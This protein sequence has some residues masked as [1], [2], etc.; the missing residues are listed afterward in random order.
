MAL[1]QNFG[2]RK[3]IKN[4]QN[5]N[6]DPPRDD[7]RLRRDD[8][9]APVR[10]N[11]KQLKQRAGV[12]VEIGVRPISVHHPG[13]QLR[14]GRNAAHGRHIVAP[15]AAGSVIRRT[16]SFLR[17]LHLEKVLKANVEQL[18]FGWGDARERITGRGRHLSECR[19]RDPTEPQ[20]QERAHPSST[21]TPSLGERQATTHR[22]PR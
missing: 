10:R 2:C 20:G 3:P 14:H 11:G 22:P 15:A 16:E 9:L 7:V 6:R 13:A 12:R 4:V 18:E 17:L 21:T 19:D 5:P 1:S 8:D